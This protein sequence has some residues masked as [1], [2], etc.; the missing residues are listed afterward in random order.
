MTTVGKI[1]VVLHLVLSIMFMAFAGAIYTA[2]TNWRVAQKKTAEDL[3]KEKKARTDAQAE[4]DKQLADAKATTDQLRNEITRMSGLNTSLDLEVKTLTADNKQLRK[5]VD[6]Q[7]DQAAL[8]TADAAERKKE[9]DLQRD[10]NGELFTS[11]DD[12]VRRLT[13]TEE[14]L[15]ALQVQ[16]QLTVEKYDQLLNNLRIINSFL[17]SKELPTDPKQMVA[18][19][20]P[21]PP[22]EGRVLDVRKPERGSRRELV[23]I[24]VG[25][26]SGLIVN[27]KMTVSRGGKYIGIVKLVRVEP[28]RS[29]GYVVQRGDKNTD[30]QVDDKVSTMY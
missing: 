19:T 12:Y 27:H 5:E 17:A 25:S 29:V 18:L 14:K 1:L 3:D 16:H 26:D 13:E 20:T 24:S 8:T 11:R 2:Q 30:F 7:R 15:F 9:A 6:Q 23:E 10:K 28:D 21:P 22:V 4:A